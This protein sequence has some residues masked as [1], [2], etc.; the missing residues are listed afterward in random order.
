ML[1][2]SGFSAVYVLVA[3]ISLAAGMAAA[4]IAYGV[5]QRWMA[6][7]SLDERYALEKKVY[8]VITLM[9]VG[10]VLRLFLVPLWFVTLS[11]LMPT[12]PG[13]MCL[14]AV[15]LTSP[16]LGFT[17]TALK[18]FLPLAYAF[19]LVVNYLDRRVESHPFMLLKLSALGPILGLMF[20][21]SLVDVRFLLKFEPEPTACCTSIF[22]V[23]R[24]G[25]PEVLMRGGWGN[26]AGFFLG[27]GLLLAAG[28]SIRRNKNYTFRPLRYAMW[29]LLFWTPISL[30]WAL[31]AQLS[32]LFL[33]KPL[34]HCVF[35]LWQHSPDTVVATV[36]IVG[37]VW[38]LAC[39]LAIV[40]AEA[41]PRISFQ[42]EGRMQR[43]SR[44][45]LGM[46]LSGGLL[47]GA[48]I[49]WTWLY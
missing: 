35:C 39:Y 4:A 46:L 14:T 10:L 20:L 9:G 24:P 38:L 17:A 44:Y 22:D 6:E 11:R 7:L 26:V 18:F 29:L 36:L 30:L 33:G 28:W 45:A 31:H 21:E 19:W 16:W 27:L 8:L 48:H 3:T 42:L 40:S 37:G 34:H 23:P 15:H 43:I 13:A 49:V 5:R 25:V 41:Y 47:L 2:V 12:V 32:P 1:V